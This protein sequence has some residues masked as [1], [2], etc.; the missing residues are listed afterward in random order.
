[1]IKQKN[2]KAIS[3][4]IATVLLIAMVIVIGLIVFLW[5]RGMV[6][7]EKTKFG[8]NIKLVCSDVEFEA[9]YDS[10]S[11]KLDISNDGNVPIFSMKV[12]I[13]EEGSHTTKNLKDI[14]N[15]WPAT[16]LNSGRTFSGNIKSEVGS[17]SKIILIPVL[18]GISEEGEKAYTCD[19]AQHGYVI[20]L[21]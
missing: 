7:E 16:G 18:V 3:P 19:E 11:G 21:S 17:A 15:E 13:F 12:Q 4:V 20:N 1:M 14:S 10:V 2:K 5:F 6:E 9:N 8:K